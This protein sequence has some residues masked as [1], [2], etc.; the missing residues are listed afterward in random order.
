[1]RLSVVVPAFNE[2]LW[3]GRCLASLAR[4]ETAYDVEV[5]VVDNNSTDR[6]VEIAESFP[7]VRVVRESRQGLV[8]ARQAG[9]VA[10]RGE[11][12]AH[13]DADSELPPDWVQ[14]IGHAFERRSD[15]VLVS[16]AMVFPGG[17][18]LAR[19]TQTLLNWAALIWWLL[20]RRLAVVNGCNFAVRT[21]ALRR[22]GGFAVDLPET[23]DSRVLTLLKPYGRAALL[24]GTPVQTSSRRFLSQGVLR[25]YAFYFLEQLGSVLGRSLEGLMS[26][27]DF[28]LP[29]PEASLRHNRRR[30]LLLLPVLPVLAV[31]GGCTY[32]AISP[33]SQV[34]GRIVLHGSRSE[35]LVALTFD[36][37]PNEPYTSEILDVLDY[38]GVK[39]TFFEVAANALYYPDSTERIVR[40]A[41]VLA[42]HSYDHSRLATAVDFKYSEVERAQTVFAEIAGV[43][44]AIFRPPAGIHTPW[45]MRRV[46]GQRMVTVNW[47][48]EGLDWQRDATAA[49]ITARVLSEVKPGSIVLLHDGDELRHGSDRSQ[50]VEALP[51]II[52]TLQARGYRFV[53][54]PQ[55]L[56]VPAYLSTTE[57][58]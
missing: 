12:V 2:E 27:P 15:M 41:H 26:A 6:T 37:G 8:C 13:T 51:T 55:L 56:H 42:N 45:Q 58:R 35:K 53:T 48:S 50:T 14:R 40:D 16:G 28:R 20:T 39:A 22:A 33:T 31:A 4:Q 17:P 36:D 46:V 18:L 38:Y 49:S 30:A 21:A 57:S 47:D 25:V 32:L 9:Q 11:V 54:V 43:Q 7:N 10:A 23:G 52:E 44:P 1:M 5:I 29:E 3:I 24:C 19:L 34:Y